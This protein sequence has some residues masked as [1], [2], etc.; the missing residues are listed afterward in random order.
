[1]AEQQDLRQFFGAL[2]VRPQKDIPSTGWDPIVARLVA[3]TPDNTVVGDQALQS[4]IVNYV[5]ANASSLDQIKALGSGLAGIKQ[6]AVQD[7]MRAFPDANLDE[8]IGAAREAGYDVQV[9]G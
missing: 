6:R 9:L 3:R 8:L 4:L 7:V 1:M 2:Y 5:V